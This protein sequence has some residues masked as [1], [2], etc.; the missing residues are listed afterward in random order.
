MKKAAV[1]LISLILAL[2]AAGCAGS[3]PTQTAPASGESGGNSQTERAADESDRNS[4][5]GPAQSEAEP[6]PQSEAE[7]ATENTSPVPETDGKDTPETDGTE[8][9]ETSPAETEPAAQGINFAE[10]ISI[11]PGEY[12]DAD[13]GFGLEVIRHRDAASN[14]EVTLFFTDRTYRL[15]FTGDL[16]TGQGSWS[17][18]RHTLGQYWITKDYIGQRIP[19]PGGKQ[20]YAAAN[21][22]NLREENP[23]YFADLRDAV[24]S[25]LMNYSPFIKDAPEETDLDGVPCWRY[26]I[27]ENSQDTDVPA[28]SRECTQIWFRRDNSHFVFA[29]TDIEAPDGTVIPDM[30][31]RTLSGREAHDFYSREA[32]LFPG[33]DTRDLQGAFTLTVVVDPGEPGEITYHCPMDR[34]EKFMTSFRDRDVYLDRAGT[35]KANILNIADT[36]TDV[37]VYVIGDGKAG[38]DPAASSEAAVDPDSVNIMDYWGRFEELCRKAGIT[39]TAKDADTFTA[40]PIES[41]RVTFS[42]RREGKCLCVDVGVDLVEADG[43]KAD[44]LRSDFEPKLLARGW[45]LMG[46][47][48]TTEKAWASWGMSPEKLV[49]TYEKHVGDDWY[50]MIVVCYMTDGGPAAWTIFICDH[51]EER[52]G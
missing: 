12:P 28:G 5:A 51:A 50:Q 22:E 33:V 24:C 45:E 41:H 34:G 35:V 20:L 39:G 26:T 21:I 15:T 47:Y 1:I 18:L 46:V 36:G 27:R 38:T 52:R 29:R 9:A 37:T 10:A 8:A 6:A 14:R 13:G 43:V 3:G 25:S 7:P 30:E 19:A 16:E 40:D 31:M 17:V 49:L 2:G 42:S 44:S 32:D 4:Q 23:I 48:P 11:N